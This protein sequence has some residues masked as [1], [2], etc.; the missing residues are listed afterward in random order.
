MG[1]SRHPDHGSAQ[2][3][4]RCPERP[5]PRR[6]PAQACPCRAGDGAGAGARAGRHGHAPGTAAKD[7]R[8]QY[9]QSFPLLLLNQSV[10]NAYQVE[11]PK[12]LPIYASV[13]VSLCVYS[14]YTNANLCMCLYIDLF[15]ER[16]DFLF[17][18]LSGNTDWAL[19]LF[20]K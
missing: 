9:L 4:R 17:F 11:T 10:R 20:F 15:N 3:S 13:C 8:G 16:G 18:F 6:L 1:S 19:E 2:G 7:G 5:R 12:L 14:I